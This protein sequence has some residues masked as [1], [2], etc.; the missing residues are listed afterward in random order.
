MH[1]MI[2][3]GFLI[4]FAG[5]LISTV[6][7][8]LVH[9]LNGASYLLFS[10]VLEVAGIT[11]V[12]GLLCAL[13]RRY[14]QRV[15]RL[16]RRFADLVVPV[17][18]LLAALS[19]FLTE[20][21]Q[22]AALTPPWADWS[23]AGNGIGHLWS[24]P[25]TANAQYVFFWWLHA[26]VSLGL[27]AA[28]PYTKLFHIVAAPLNVY[29]YDTL[30][31][32]LPT[33]KSRNEGEVYC[34]RDLLSFDACTRCGR[35]VD[36]CP[37]TLAGEPFS[38]RDFILW[39]GTGQADDSRGFA[40]EKIWHC[41]TCRA[42]QEVC[43][44]YIAAPDP[45]RLARTQVVE[46]GKNVPPLLNQTLKKL[47]KYDNP[48]EPSRM[49][50]ANWTKGLSIVDFSK[51][52]T[53]EGACYFVGCTTSM[54]TRAQGLARSFSR[55]LQYANVPFGILG[56]KEPCC[57]DIARRAGE[58]GLFEEQASN[59]VEIFARFNVDQLI[60]SSPHCFNAIRNEYPG[61]PFERVGE[62]PSGDK[63]LHYS[64]FLNQLLKKGALRFERPLSL[65]VTYHDPCYLGRYN[66]IFDAPREV[67][68]AI[69]GVELLQMKHERSNSLCC[70]G[71]GCRMWQEDL[72]A[73]T[74]M[75]DIRIR[76]AAAT[77]AQVVVTACPLCLIMLEDARKT[78][79]LADSIKVMD[80]NELVRMALEQ[81]GIPFEG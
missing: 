76:E 48:W 27:I 70:G 36:V 10:L 73:D 72:D 24:R 3:W 25:E 56:N 35:C 13:A 65:K 64:Q 22:L 5:T 8:Y 31:P 29:L 17:W 2:L 19:G 75:S 57:G 63:I 23:F 15:S 33:E 30:R 78:C 67:I 39:A 28:I 21:A 66:N 49:R 62:I 32:V 61:L 52:K 69:P 38:P 46:E 26:V 60:V 43:P 37:S 42:C 58:S 12:A 51:T 11:L 74:K 9:F 77:G 44:V 50:R 81:T 41:T 79:G 80:L 20:G 71:G 4:L 68:T 53:A 1:L 18:L 34:F 16:E 59:C 14:V 55:I 45:I 7:H 6:D 54:D 47:F 40:M